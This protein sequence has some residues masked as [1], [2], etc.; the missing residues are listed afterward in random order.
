MYT[1]NVVTVDNIAHYP[2]YMLTVALQ[3]RIEI[4]LSLIFNEQFGTFSGHMVICHM[5]C[6]FS[7]RTVGVNPSMQFHIASMAFV[8]H[9][10]QR[11]PPWRASLHTGHVAAPRFKTGLIK[12]IA[13][14]THLEYYSIDIH[15][16]QVIEHVNE[17]TLH[18]LFVH[19]HEL[20]VHGLYPCSA[21]FALGKFCS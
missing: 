5:L 18:L 17:I 11:V 16:L 15:L 3:R 21:E 4:Q 1:V 12:G 8:Y 13:L 9:E 2:A 10:S 20:P 14:Y 7:A 19:S 6:S